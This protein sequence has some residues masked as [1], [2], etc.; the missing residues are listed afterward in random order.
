[1]VV[2]AAGMDT[3]KGLDWE[4]PGFASG[5]FRGP[6][7]G[8]PMVARLTLLAFLIAVAPSLGAATAEPTDAGA[9]RAAPPGAVVAAPDGRSEMELV[10][11]DGAVAATLQDLAPGESVHVEEWPVAP[12]RRAS[13]VLRRF[14]VYAPD[15]KVVVIEDGVE[16]EEPRSSQ[17]FFQG[18]V[19]AGADA[20][21][22]LVAWLDPASGRFGG[23]A[24]MGDGV[25]ELAPP[26]EASGEATRVA[27]AESLEPAGTRTSWSCGVPDGGSDPLWNALMA[28]R[29]ERPAFAGPNGG[30]PSAPTAL[31]KSA[32]IAFDTDAEYLNLRFANNTSSATTY[33]AQLVAAMTVIY[34]RDV[35]AA[36]GDGVKVLQGY[37]ILRVGEAS[38]PY[39]D[40]TGSADSAKLAEFRNYWN[41]QY[42]ETVVRRALAA[43]LSGRQGSSNSA[44]GIATVAALCSTSGYSIDQ[45]FTGVFGVSSDLLILAHEVGHNFGAFHT[46][47]CYYGTPPIDRCVAPEGGCTTATGCP[48]SQT[49]NGVT[50]NGTLMSYCHMLDCSPYSLVFHNR[51]I[52]DNPADPFGIDS[53]LT[54][55]ANAGCLA[56]LSGG[57]VPAAPTISSVA[58]ASGP[59]AGGTAVTITGTNFTSG[60][61]VSFVE[62]PSNNV[63]GDSVNSKSAA[64][65]TFNGSTQLTA[66]TPSA[67]NAGA[68][69]VVVMNPDRQTATRASGFTYTIAGPAPTVTSVS[70][71]NGTTAG[72]T[73]VTITGTNFVATPSVTFGGAAATAEVFVNATTLTATVPAH[74]AGPVNVVVTNPDAQSGTLTNGYAYLP[75]ASAS[76]YWVL[77]PCRLFDTRNAAGADAA[78]PILAAGETRT[79]DVSGRCGVPDAS[80]ALTVNATVTGPGAAGE[81]RIYPGNGVSPNPPASTLSYAAGRTRA[82]NSVVRLATDGTATLKVQNVSAAAV[83]FILD[84]SGYFLAP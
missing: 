10:R 82:N 66:T 53:V 65:V 8:V 50:T 3:P 27:R 46:H 69:D 67:T 52:T 74:A 61:T 83:H 79:F 63:F 26:D 34:E 16:R 5:P 60:A 36:M 44:S 78:A 75:P 48:G 37:T 20:G 80:I 47:S 23:L 43:L 49:F 11:F 7:G 72:G 56:A 13:V 42:P 57:V 32:V 38:D 59:L 28:A 17:A 77:T 14:D 58:P 2:R 4:Y 19:A 84:V 12:G 62:L 64:S 54:E 33:I 30:A 51:S 9:L 39:S 68:V 45:L 31:S 18:I 1:M 35:A 29:T 41:A 71:N 24:L 70:P 15:A 6:K 25:F 22:R 55:V 76:R 21:K 81:I 40:T 73:S